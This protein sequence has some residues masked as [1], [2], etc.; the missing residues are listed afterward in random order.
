MNKNK[1]MINE[2]LK[3]TII[4]CGVCNIYPYQKKKVVVKEK[5]VHDTG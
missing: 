2:R 3:V 1:N 5:E 4:G